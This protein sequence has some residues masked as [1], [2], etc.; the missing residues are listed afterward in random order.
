[1]LELGI[2]QVQA[3]FTK[4][5][6]KTVVIIDKKSHI[7]K[8]VIIPYEEYMHLI[9]KSLPKENI[10]NGIFNKFA[11]VLDNELKTDDEKYNKV[12]N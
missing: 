12:I 4:L 1:M 10:D 9:K 2:A 11:G 7:K 8:A 6:N 3:Q 5:L